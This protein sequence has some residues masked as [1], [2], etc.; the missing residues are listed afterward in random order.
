MQH[1]GVTCR[2]TVDGSMNCVHLCFN[3]VGGLNR[4]TLVSVCCEDFQQTFRLKVDTVHL[5]R[6]TVLACAGDFNYGQ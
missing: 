3:V 6:T 5:S 4:H 2:C 1:I